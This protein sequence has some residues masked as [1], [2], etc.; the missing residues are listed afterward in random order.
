MACLSKALLLKFSNKLGGI[1][2]PSLTAVGS[3]F[4]T[5]FSAT[6]GAAFAAAIC[7]TLSFF[8]SSFL[9]VYTLIYIYIYI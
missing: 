8:S 7:F 3:A 9:I 6:G 1:T 2:P 5:E 4:C